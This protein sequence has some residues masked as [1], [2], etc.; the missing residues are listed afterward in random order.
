MFVI[1]RGARDPGFANATNAAVAVSTAA[2]T[3]WNSGASS[4]AYKQAAR[5]MNQTN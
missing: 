2:N 1:R 4:A 3:T 5:M